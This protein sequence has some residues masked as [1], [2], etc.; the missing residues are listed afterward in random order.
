MPGTAGTSQALRDVLENQF[1][2]VRSGYRGKAA[3][4]ACL[5]RHSLAHTDELRRLVT[6]GREVRWALSLSQQEDHLKM[7]SIS[8]GVYKI[9]FDIT[10]FYD[11][12]VTVCRHAM[13]QSYAGKVMQRY[14][15]WLT[16]DLD[17]AKPQ[18]S[19][20]RAAI[21]EINML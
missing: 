18:T 17:T 11:D 5:F 9:R 12:L 1:E 3:M 15:A 13:G 21:A 19:D 16:L 7:C 20:M 6:Q 4:L 14:N 10:A 2:A 8:P